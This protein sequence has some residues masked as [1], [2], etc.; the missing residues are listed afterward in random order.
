MAISY[1]CAKCG[2]RMNADQ[3]LVRDMLCP[4]CRVPM[5]REDVVAAGAPVPAPSVIGV[6]KPRP[7][8]LKVARIVAPPPGGMPVTPTGSAGTGKFKV[9]ATVMDTVG[10][11]TDTAQRIRLQAQGTPVSVAPVVPGAADTAAQEALLQAREQAGQLV[12]QAKTEASALLAQAQQAAAETT[13]QA[14]EQAA[15]TA[16]AAT[17]AAEKV[18]AAAQAAVDQELAAAQAEAA[19]ITADA[20][21][22]ADK[23]TAEAHAAA[24]TAR[25]EAGRQTLAADKIVADAKA[26]ADKV[27]ADAKAAAE[28]MAAEAKTAADQLVAEARKTA[29]TQ[30]SQAKAA[31][32]AGET[33]AAAG[34]TA[35]NVPGDQSVVAAVPPPSDDAKAPAASAGDVKPEG[36]KPVSE[37]VKAETAK[38]EIVNRQAEV[39]KAVKREANLLMGGIVGSAVTA[40]YLVFILAR[41]HPSPPLKIISWLM[42]MADTGAFVFLVAIIW[43][44]YAAGTKAVAR[45]KERMAGPKPATSGTPGPAA[46]PG[47]AVA[48][49]AGGTADSAAKPGD[50]AKIAAPAGKPGAFKMAPPKKPF[51]LAKPKAGTPLLAGAAAQKPSDAKA[52]D[53][54]EKVA[55][56]PVSPEKAAGTEGKNGKNG[57][58]GKT[59]VPA[60][61]NAAAAAPPATPPPADAKNPAAKPV[62]AKAS[63]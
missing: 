35:P 13:T 51:G 16:A 53:G 37:V 61:E 10:R 44:H 47:K 5:R 11:M 45:H 46:G 21:T 32:A 15:Q 50:A 29:E 1:V 39:T 8:G 2:A 23:V 20:R 38:S 62:D 30:L 33:N 58:D 28:K 12:A 6:D 7:A 26:A 60:G 36:P 54:A 25:D 17:V 55:S 40:L 31:G 14:Q 57:T 27:A 4:V 41:M 56:A 9:A 42:L 52:G 18:V 3:P 34:T 19:K 48:G 59:P 22:A 43:G 49:A 63:V 24:A